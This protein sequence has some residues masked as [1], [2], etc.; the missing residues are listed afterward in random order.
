MELYVHFQSRFCY[1]FQ[2]WHGKSFN[3]IQTFNNMFDIFCPK[4]FFGGNCNSHLMI[5]SRKYCVSICPLYQVWNTKTKIRLCFIIRCCCHFLVLQTFT[6][7]SG[8]FIPSILYKK[9]FDIK[10]FLISDF[11]CDFRRSPSKWMSSRSAL[12]VDDIAWLRVRS[13]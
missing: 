13:S 10:S 5:K 3:S 9:Q 12:M 4:L 1:P 8:T 11:I 7:V 6:V 2:S